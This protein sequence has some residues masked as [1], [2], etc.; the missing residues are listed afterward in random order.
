[1]GGLFSRVVGAARLNFVKLRADGSL[2]K[3]FNPW[4]SFDGPVFSISLQSDGK[5]LASG[6]FK[7]VVGEPF[8]ALVRLDNDGRI[9]HG[10]KPEITK[11]TTPGV[12]TVLALPDGRILI[13]GAFDRSGR[14]FIH[15]YRAT[16]CRWISRQDF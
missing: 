1:M 12:Y 4:L 13:G 14:T 2:D 10:F 8:P 5:I 6:F 3:T 16:E 9:D 15:E 7:A 11:K